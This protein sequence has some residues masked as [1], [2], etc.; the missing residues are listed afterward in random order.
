MAKLSKSD[1]LKRYRQRV[2]HA[3][4]WRT[5]EGYDDT[6]RRMVDLYKGKHFPAS[7]EDEDRIAVNMAFSTINTIYPSITIN[8]P[9][10]EI[11]ANKPEDD[12]KA[13]IAGAVVNYWWK[14]YD[15]RSPFRRATK[16]FLILGHGW[17]KVGYRYEEGQESKSPDELAVEF[18]QLADE[19]DMYAEQNPEMAGELPTDEEIE[20]NL[21]DT[22]VVVREDRPFIERVDPFDMFVD[23]EATCMDDARWI[24]QRIVRP[25]EDVRA[26]KRYKEG[27]RRKVTADSTVRSDWMGHDERKRMDTDIDRVT[28]YEFYDLKDGTVSVFTEGSSDFLVDPRSMPYAF[29]HP[30]EFIGNYEIPGDFYPVGD[31]EMIEGVQQELNKTRSQMMNHRKKYARKYLFRAS[32]LSPEGR[33]GLES[34][35]DNVAIEVVDDNQPLQDVILPVPITPLSGD[36][37][38]YSDIVEADIDRISGV[39]E[40]G[41]GGH[42]E[43]K[44]TATEAAMIQDAANARSA[45]K[46]AIIEVA[47]GRIASKVVALAQQYM[48]G[49]QVARVIGSEQQQLWIDFTYED[50]SGEFDF[51][52]EGGSTQPQ[53]ETFRRQ[54]AIAM[55]NSLGPMIGTVIDPA[56]IAKHVLQF[57]FG[58]KSPG[59]FMLQQQPQPMQG[60]QGMTPDVMAGAGG[61]PMQPPMPMPPQG[62]MMPPAGAG[63]DAPQMDPRMLLELQ[64]QMG[65]SGL[66]D[67]AGLGAGGLPPERI[68]QLQNQMG[69]R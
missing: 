34:N 31:L 3:R 46:L 24:A 50:I 22:K 52:V 37:Y 1:K 18:N 68:R 47:I 32:A 20:A 42:S 17:V 13:V 66:E 63:V 25:I 9:K 36:L 23:P 54:Q 59:K 64:Q 4:S 27:V 38:Q 48:T 8:H 35:Q 41:R 2:S 39:N 33:Q 12:D 55:M 5:R 60:P 6:W 28:L 69:L 62:G 58:V 15:F 45:D 57:G 49:T 29:G 51:T 67:L 14:H 21:A 44:R 40:Y 16:D 65:Q 53:N 56:A 10:I 26:D 11:Y 43:M 7:L 19:A 61:P 30:Y